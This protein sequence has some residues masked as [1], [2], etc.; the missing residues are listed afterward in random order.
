MKVAKILSLAALVSGCASAADA[1][2]YSENLVGYINQS[3]D[4]GDNYFANQLDNGSDTL[5]TIFNSGV[6]PEGSTFTEWNPTTQQ[7]LPASTYDTVNGWSINYSLTCGQGGL[8]DTP[9][10]FVNTFTG[11]V[12]LG[13][14]PASGTFTPPLVTGTGLQFLSSYVP[15]DDAGF[16]DVVGRDPVNGESV[17]TLDAATQTY[18]TTTFEN[19]VWDHGAPELGVGEAAFYDL[20]VVPHAVF[21]PE[22]SAA[23]LVATAAAMVLAL[24]GLRRLAKRRA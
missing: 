20:D 1:Q 24:S 6:V 15:V 19:G 13:F 8:L 4:T 10:S 9:A 22:P 2:V 21:A 11:S 7:F 23:N 12:W 16:Y 5:S 18:A 17:T 3:F 14:Q